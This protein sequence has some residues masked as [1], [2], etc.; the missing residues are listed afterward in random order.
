MGIF[1]EGVASIQVNHLDFILVAIVRN[2]R[3]P[4]NDNDGETNSG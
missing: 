2:C 4:F 1:K 3:N